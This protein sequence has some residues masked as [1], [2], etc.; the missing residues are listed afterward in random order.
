MNS[1][2][3]PSAK[4][5]AMADRID[6]NADSGFGGAICIVPP[7]GGETIELLILEATDNPAQFWGII[8]ARAIMALN[9][10]EQ[11]RAMNKAFGR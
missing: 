7:D 2:Q 6:K 5:R 11:D 1:D 10:I 9:K 8:Q 3:S 4:F